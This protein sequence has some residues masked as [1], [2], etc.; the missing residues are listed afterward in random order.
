MTSPL[1]DTAWDACLL[2]PVR[3][4]ALEAWA[5]RRIGLPH[6]T[7]RYFARAPWV[8]RML[9][10]WLPEQGL[11]VELDL[12]EADLVG[13]VV[14][15]E[16]SCRF[17]Y[18]AVRAMLRI[19]GLSE[20]RVQRLER[21][22]A[23]TEVEPRLAALVRFTRRMAR[24]DPPLAPSDVEA[25]R[26][27]GFGAGAIRE[28]MFA[29]A[30]NGLFNRTATLGALPPREFERLP[31]L[32]PVRWL[33]PLLARWMERFRR[34]GRL[35]PPP[36]ADGPMAG[37][38][39]ALGDSPVAAMLQQTFAEMWAST[40]LSARCRAL[41]IAVVARA[42]G[43]LRTGDDMVQALAQ[44]AIGAARLEQILSHL[45]APEL[46]AAERVLVPFARE[47]VWYVPQQLQRRTRE[48]AARVEATMLTEAIG[49]LALANAV[50]RLR[51]A[52]AAAG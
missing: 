28:L 35:A 5:R 24:S 49:T 36:A 33:R 45:D 31:D 8:A 39:A 27:A 18:A 6:P 34:R 40:A 32:L 29:V 4:P 50:C 26:A 10:R 51:L 41:L 7:V 3:D 15:Q 30:G 47:T 46:P 21:Q 17:C 19:Q 43:D 14:S 22:L 11:L 23:D 44:D 2:E 12:H 37:L 13:L 1:A 42:L 9:V 20:E 52:L 25:L 16:N 38:V 48:L